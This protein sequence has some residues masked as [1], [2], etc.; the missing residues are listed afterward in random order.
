MAEGSYLVFISHSS[1]DKWIAHQ[2]ARL[3]EERGEGYGVKTFLDEKDI[4]G[5]DSIPEEI[6]D[7]I[8]KCDELLVLLSPYS[9]DRP[10]VLIEI[11]AAWGQQ[12]RI[13]AIIDKISP[14]DMPDVIEQHKAIDLNDFE[15]YLN[16]LV[17]RA[18]EA[19]TDE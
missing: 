7:S 1:K 5:G 18:R 15:D 8:Q 3:V 9:V 19:Q 14:A 13:V 4:E 10:W 17:A 2:I 12:K 16:Q 11:G 6:R